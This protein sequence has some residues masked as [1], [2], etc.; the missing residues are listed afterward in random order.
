MG[1]YIRATAFIA[2]AV[3]A[4]AAWGQQ[5]LYDSA[6]KA[7]GKYTGDSIIISRNNEPVRIYTDADWDY[8][9]G[10]PGS[11]GLTWKYVPLY[12]ASPNCSPPYYISTSPTEPKAQ[13]GP[14][15]GTG[16]AY[17]PPA[18]GSQ[19]LVA[20]WK[21]GANWYAFYSAKNPNYQQVSIQS[22]YQYDGSCAQKY[23]PNMWVTPFLGD[24]EPLNIYG[25][26]PFYVK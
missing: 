14:T 10:S 24:A 11:S 3:S 13:G 5:D 6:N 18:Y 21:G 7:V 9:K 20:T 8:S 12:S 19:Y 16:A 25:T 23:Y 26:P 22:Q 4:S 15:P 2:I 17:T 1:T